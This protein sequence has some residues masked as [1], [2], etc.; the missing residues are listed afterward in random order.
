MPTA[1]SGWWAEL[2]R[3]SGSSGRDARDVLDPPAPIPLRPLTAMADR[4]ALLT[5]AM[6]EAAR[7]AGIIPA[8][9]PPPEGSDALF[10]QRLARDTIETEPLYLMMAAVLAVRRGAPAALALSRLQPADRVANADEIAGSERNRLIRLARAAHA[11]ERLLLH[12]AACITLQQGCD[13]DGLMKLLEQE[14]AARGAVTATAEALVP[15]LHDALAARDGSGV[16]AVRPDLIGEAFLL[17][18][19]GRDR[20]SAARQA[21]IVERA[22]D[23]AGTRVVATVIRTAQDHAQGDAAHAS[24]AW[25]DHLARLTDDPFALIAIA[26]EL[27]AQTLALRERAAEIQARIVAALAER[28]PDDPDMLSPLA[29]AQNDLA[30]RL[31]DLGEREAALAAAR[32]AVE[33]RRTLAAQRPDA[34]RPDLAASLNTLA[35]MLR[36]L[37]E[38]EAALAAAREA[39]E[40]HRALAAQRPDAFRPDLAM[41]L[42]NLAAML[43]ELGEREAA[44]AAAREAAELYRALA[45]QR[46]DAFRPYLAGSLNNLAPMLSE[47]GEREAALAAAREAVDLRRALAAQRPDAFRP[48]LARSLNNLAI[49]L[50]ELGER[51]A[52]LAAAREAAELYRA[53]AAQR[54]DAFRPDLAR[55]L[56][57]R[58]DCLDATDQPEA[59]LADNVEAISVLTPAF[60]RLPQAFASLMKAI[61]RGYRQRCEARGIEPDETLLAPVVAAFQRLQAQQIPEQ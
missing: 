40:L 26:A 9:V 34:F 7:I 3:P 15:L 24:V 49:R 47:L 19:L 25:L 23:R 13:D 56:W 18:E 20:R 59:A 5:E 1:S 60:V 16:D 53:L 46:P 31:R 37:G 61:G 57:V 36:E 51:E 50:R 14:C 8:P 38:R 35:A 54:P 11:D 43:R 33:L 52:A 2:T 48:D 6:Q 28:A 39:A 44:L 17:R 42:N 58:A 21:A 55:S 29:A 4:R 32:E 41:S 30:V 10:D 22:F 45:A 27:A 12:A